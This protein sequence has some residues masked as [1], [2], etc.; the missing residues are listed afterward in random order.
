MV[1]HYLPAGDYNSILDLTNNL[2]S[3]Q[4]IPFSSKRQRQIIKDSRMGKVGKPGSKRYQRYLN[5][6]FL[7][8]QQWDL[9]PEDFEVIKFSCSPFSVLFEET[10]R[11]KWAP[12]VDITEEKQNQL[13]SCLR[14][15]ISE[16]EK[17][18]E[19]G[20]FV[21]VFS[22]ALQ[23]K[24]FEDQEEE[25]KTPPSP[26]AELHFRKV[27]KKIR[28]F[29]RKNSDLQI[30][31]LLDQEIVDYI[32]L[33]TYQPKRFTFTESLHRMICHGICQFYTLSSRS[34]D[35]VGGSRAV[36]V[37]KPKKGVCFPSMTLT[38]FLQTEV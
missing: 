30:I 9:K 37:R 32:Q 8:E 25:V 3:T 13:L 5:K 6:S 31:H 35:C 21:Y 4:H 2:S 23:I 18:D 15:A 34:E 26:P 16:D 22:E 11:R 12:F 17:Y 33:A 10:N 7:Q 36:V 20:D 19:F 28:K 29:I 1:Q 38:K 27:E 14:G 24:D